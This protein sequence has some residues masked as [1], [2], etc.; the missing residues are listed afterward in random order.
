MKWESLWLRT[1]IREAPLPNHPTRPTRVALLLQYLVLLG[2][3][4]LA[5]FAALSVVRPSSTMSMAWPP[6]RLLVDGV[7][8][9]CGPFKGEGKRMKRGKTLRFSVHGPQ[10]GRVALA[11]VA[12]LAHPIVPGLP[13]TL[14]AAT[15]AWQYWRLL[16][17]A[18][19]WAPAMCRRVRAGRP[20][21]L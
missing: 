2:G 16:E 8:R 10:E 7:T 1:Q 15:L 9:G 17:H 5:E 13:C 3:L 4:V 20:R 12:V 18:V 19:L 21:C 14:E 6:G 11:V